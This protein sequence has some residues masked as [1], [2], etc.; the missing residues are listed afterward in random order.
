MRLKHPVLILHVVRVQDLLL[1]PAPAAAAVVPAEVGSV[2]SPV[3][4]GAEEIVGTVVEGHVRAVRTASP[5][6]GQERLL[7]D[8][9]RAIPDPHLDG[10]GRP[11]AEERKGSVIHALVAV[12][13][14][15]IFV[16]AHPDTKIA[17][18]HHGRTDDLEVIQGALV[19]Q[20]DC[21]L[22]KLEKRKF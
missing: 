4:D 10:S 18:R 13:T 1:V 12:S 9:V 11:G 19:F 22:F 2:S 20:Q 17:N 8:H 3:P 21:L 7:P 6:P 14:A 15:A 16:E 5:T